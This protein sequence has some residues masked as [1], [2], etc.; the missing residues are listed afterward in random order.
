[1]KPIAAL[2][3][4]VSMLLA[5]SGANPRAVT[6]V[7]NWA[8]GDVTRVAIEISGDFEYRTDRLQ[9]PDR[10]YYDILNA[11]PYVEGR[12][13]WSR[14]LSDKLVTKVRVAE[15]AP[16]VTRV[17]LELGPDV[18]ISTSQLTSPYRLMVEVRAGK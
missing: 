12:R 13:F 2:A 6:A 8:L 3:I 16:S 1:M 7:R 17:V 4:S 15:T 5:Q 9:N 14:E 10:V 11:R 18:E